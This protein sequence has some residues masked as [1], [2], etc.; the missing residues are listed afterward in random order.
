MSPSTSHTHAHTH[1]HPHSHILPHAHMQPPQTVGDDAGKVSRLA[2]ML[3]GV[4]GDTDEVVLIE[5]G[6]RTMGRL[7]KGGGALTSDIVE[8]EVGGISQCAMA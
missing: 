7:V 4:L 2:A 5:W 6:A 1:T 3:S 8:R